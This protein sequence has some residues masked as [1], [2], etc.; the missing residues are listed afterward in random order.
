MRFPVWVG[1][2]AWT[3]ACVL[4]CGI[5]ILAWSGTQWRADVDAMWN[6]A[7]FETQT[8]VSQAIHEDLAFIKLA[9]SAVTDIEQSPLLQSSTISDSDQSNYQPASL[10][11]LFNALDGG[12]GRT[13]NSLGFMRRQS[14]TTNGK[15]SWQ[16]AKGFGCSEYMYA[17]ANGIIYP[18]F[19]GYCA[20][21]AN[22][23]VLSSNLAY[24][25]TDWGLKPEEAQLLDGKR[26]ALFLPVFNLLGKFML[27]HEMAYGVGSFAVSF[28][29]AAL[30][31]FTQMV[32]NIS[33]LDGKGVVYVVEIPTGAMLASNHPEA[34]IADN[35]QRLFA[36][37]NTHDSIRE[38]YPIA[39][40]AA[41]ADKD[42]SGIELID[43]SAGR[44]R[45]SSDRYVDADGI[46]WLI[47]VSVP[48]H[49]IFG[50]VRHTIAVVTGVCVV[51]LVVLCAFTCAVFYF[52]LGRPLN[53][54]RAR[55]ASG[56][57][58]ESN[59]LLSSWFS[60][61]Q[62]LNETYTNNHRQQQQISTH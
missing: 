32:A 12:S 43:G 61:V 16:I 59:T 20:L 7:A 8:R 15:L 57:R 3:C 52:F 13:F 41:L 31:T 49:A 30:D 4:I 14:P 19:Y 54:L 34:V 42:P 10:I 35:N 38:T 18:Q 58:E 33:I 22:A 48:S 50:H 45:I 47:V 44:W 25:G 1:A 17:Y 40:V 2:S 60:E 6:R 11:R 29:E 46:D 55:M 27:T 36:I 5:V 23:Q 53:R 37:N 21:E 62:D 26:K 56:S 51:L 24:N 9:S 39:L 28:A